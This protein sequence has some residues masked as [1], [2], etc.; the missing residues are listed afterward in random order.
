[1]RVPVI[2]DQPLGLLIDAIPEKG[3]RRRIITTLVESFI[4]EQDST[5]KD[6]IRTASS[7]DTQSFLNDVKDRL[8]WRLTTHDP[9]A[10]QISVSNRSLAQ[11]LESEEV[12][13]ALIE[14]SAPFR[15]GESRDS[16][17]NKKIKVAVQRASRIEIVDG[18]VAQQLMTGASGTNWFLKKVLDNFN[19]VISIVSGEPWDDRNA[20]AGVKAKRDLVTHRIGELLAENHRFTGEI[21]LT[22]LSGKKFQHNRRLGIRFDS[23]QA[24]VLLEAGLGTFSKDPFSESH[25]LKNADLVEFKKVITQSA[26]TKDKHEIIVR[27]SDVCNLVH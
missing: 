1:M 14:L 5:F 24:I 12:E 23:G 19:G 11:A 27:H 13:K 2:F 20:P 22:L 18:F 26:Q 21:R 7:S 15:S 17:F 10:L 16:G 4:L 8:C 9:E 3:T 6:A 25:E